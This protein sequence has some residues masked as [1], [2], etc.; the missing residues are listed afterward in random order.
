MSRFCSVVL[1]LN[2]QRERLTLIRYPRWKCRLSN[3]KLAQLGCVCSIASWGTSHD[4]VVYVEEECAQ[5][6]RRRS[7]AQ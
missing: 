1:L 4:Y 2:R 6:H 7:G 3:A 5:Q